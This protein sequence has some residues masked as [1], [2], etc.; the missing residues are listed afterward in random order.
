MHSPP[1]DHGK[2]LFPHTFFIFLFSLP[3]FPVL[4]LDPRDREG[5]FQTGEGTDFFSIYFF[6]EALRAEDV[7]FF[8]GAAFFSA[9][10]EALF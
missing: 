9:S 3:L 8:S 10:L 5:F 2:K 6:L 1:G 4:L 7:F